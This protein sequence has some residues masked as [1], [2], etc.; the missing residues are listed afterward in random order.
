MEGDEF[1]TANV[2]FSVVLQWCQFLVM[3]VNYAMSSHT[4]ELGVRESVIHE[5]TIFR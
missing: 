5:L 2:N 1:V 3:R 4:F